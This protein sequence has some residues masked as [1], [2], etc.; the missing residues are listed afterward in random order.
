M[1]TEN[2]VPGRA[3]DRALRVRNHGTVIVRPRSSIR[4]WRT[5]TPPVS[6]RTS[7]R[8][9]HEDGEQDDQRH[10][11]DQ[12][13]DQPLERPDRRPGAPAVQVHDRD[14]VD[15]LARVSGARPHRGNHAGAA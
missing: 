9:H 7:K 14:A 3:T 4:G 12:H 10:Q 8:Q 11:G 1:A 15:Q 5:S 13:L 6:T 2:V